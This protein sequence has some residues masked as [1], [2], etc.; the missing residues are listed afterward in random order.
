MT[1]FT[2]LCR[3]VGVGLAVA[4]SSLSMTHVAHAALPSPTVPDSKIAA[5]AGNEAFLVGHVSTGVQIYKCDGTSW[6]F[7]APRAD[8]VDEKGQLIIT[9]FAGPTWQATD[10]SSVVAAR[11][12]GVTVD[13][14]AIPWLLL[15]AT[16]TTAGRG[17]NL[18]APTTFIQRINTVGGLA[19]TDRCNA[20]KSGTV[21]E[22]P[23]GADYFFYKSTK[24]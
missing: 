3:G 12:D 20:A 17:G 7:V 21:K 2:R 11:V 13:P 19:P 22:V 9:H 18:L 6:T 15:K 1:R 8:L 16:K 10:G 5:P 24:G 14:N 23:Y 4:A